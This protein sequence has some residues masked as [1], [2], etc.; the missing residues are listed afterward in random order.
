M[1]QTQMRKEPI[2]LD[3]ACGAERHRCRSDQCS[4]R[5]ALTKHPGRGSI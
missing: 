2:A 1:P 3:V 5:T 4:V